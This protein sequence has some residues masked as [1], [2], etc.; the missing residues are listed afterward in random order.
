MYVSRKWSH[1]FAAIQHYWG[2][3]LPNSQET[4]G[5]PK[6]KARTTSLTPEADAGAGQH[7]EKYILIERPSTGQTGA[8]A[9]D[10]DTMK[11]TL[12]AHVKAIA[13]VL[14]R[15]EVH[16]GGGTEALEAELASTKMDLL[17][18][19]EDLRQAQ[20]QLTDTETHLHNTKTELVNA[21]LRLSIVEETFDHDRAVNKHIVAQLSVAR[22]GLV[23]IE[24]QINLL[25]ASLVE[26]CDSLELARGDGGGGCFLLL[27][28]M[29]P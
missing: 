16:Q 25:R 24:E 6:R 5:R 12:G 19:Q 20:Q 18:A 26:I 7:A 1:E 23:R 4:Q 17:T 2:T 3:K 28:G 8:V 11:A 15:L 13:D 10:S 29:R 22:L 9:S 21:K 27:E 14:A